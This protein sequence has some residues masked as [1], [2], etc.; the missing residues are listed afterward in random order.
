[1]PET[2]V[3][4]NAAF[5]KPWKKKG[6]LE[7]RKWTPQAKNPKLVHQGFIL[8]SNEDTIVSGQAYLSTGIE[9][10]LP[11]GMAAMVSSIEGISTVGQPIA[12]LSLIPL[13]SAQLV[14]AGQ[15]QEVQPSPFVKNLT[16]D[17]EAR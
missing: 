13:A 5:P 4:V 7:A 2:I 14:T 1:M 8:Y 17:Q 9:V 11:E 10:H 6:I 3:Q 15:K 16:P 12:K